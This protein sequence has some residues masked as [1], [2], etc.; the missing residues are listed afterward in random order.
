LWRRIASLSSPR[1]HPHTEL[2]KCASSVH[3]H[4][5]HFNVTAPSVALLGRVTIS[6]DQF[7][8]DD[9]PHG[10]LRSLRER[11][12]YHAESTSGLRGRLPS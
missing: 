2:S 12:A 1:I 9:Q 8:F 10:L 6:V 11:S 3:W 4:P 7:G 5:Q